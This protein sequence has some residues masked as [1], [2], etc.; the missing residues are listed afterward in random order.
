[1]SMVAQQACHFLL[2]GNRCRLAPRQDYRDTSR[3]EE[4]ASHPEKQEATPTFFLSVVDEE[5]DEHASS[6]STSELLCPC[7]PLS[8]SP[9]IES[10]P[11][12]MSRLLC[13]AITQSHEKEVHKRAM[14]RQCHPFLHKYNVPTLDGDGEPPR[15]K[16]GPVTQLCVL[17]ENPP[18]AQVN[19]GIDHQRIGQEQHDGDGD[20]CCR[21]KPI[22]RNVIKNIGVDVGSEADVS[23]HPKQQD[24]GAVDAQ[25]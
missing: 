25:P 16:L 19:D 21:G 1:M 22:C 18:L 13:E 10:F 20:I 23:R 24:Q 2:H 3:P 9:T 7:P 12:W 11:S 5:E 17:G 8:E 14:R 15:T 6:S 4:V